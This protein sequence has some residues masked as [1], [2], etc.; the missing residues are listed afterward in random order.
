MYKQCA[1]S[2]GIAPRIEELVV[3]RRRAAG[4]EGRGIGG[5]EVF[6]R[7]LFGGGQMT[8]ERSNIIVMAPR[9]GIDPGGNK[10]SQ[11]SI[12]GARCFG[13]RRECISGQR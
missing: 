7:S 3:A 4:A 6:T 2:G 8:L 13:W 10:S 5:G 1:D 11:Q 12:T 9:G